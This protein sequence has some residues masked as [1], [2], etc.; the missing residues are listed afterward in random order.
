MAFRA[1]SRSFLEHWVLLMLVTMLIS[2]PG[3]TRT[4]LRRFLGGWASSLDVSYTAATT[5]PPSRR[6]RLNGSLLDVLLLVTGLAPLLETSLRAEPCEKLYATDASPSGAGG[7]F[8]SIT[9]EDCL[10]LY[11]LV[12]AKVSTFAVKPSNMHDVRAAAAPLAL[13][14]NW[15]TMFSCRFLAGK[16]INLQFHEILISLFR[17][18]TREAPGTC[19]FARSL[20]GR[21]KR[22]IE[23]RKI[24][25]LLRKLRF[26]CLAYDVALELLWAPTWAKLA[27]APSRSKPIES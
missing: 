18:I 26:L 2:A 13:K 17:R 3:V 4:L 9:R 10:A 5:L 24:N 16:H 23:S 21:L 14:L 1:H 12:E 7:C 25:F 27:D 6:C 22:T 11:D 8:A 20:G 15:T 19:G